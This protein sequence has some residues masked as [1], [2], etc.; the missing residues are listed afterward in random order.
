MRGEFLDLSGARLYYYAAGTRG[1]GVPVVFIHGF[2]TSG[3]LW[4]EVVPL[5]PH[6]HRLVVLD[7]LGYG[8]SDRPLNR[9][10][11]VRAHATRVIAVLDE[12]RIP[13]A[14]VVGHGI[15]GGVAQ[16]LAI[17]HPARVS[18]LCLIDSVA[19]DR[20]PT[21]EARI[22]RAS[23]AVTRYLPPELLLRVVRR[24]MQRGYA[25]HARATHSIELY[26][27]PFKEHDG[28]RALVSH[29]RAL[30]SRETIKLGRQLGKIRAPTAIVWGEHDRVMPLSVARRL[31][32]AIAGATLE[33]LPD[34]R[35]FTPEEAP[36]QIA[37]NIEALLG[38]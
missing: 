5:M 38:R 7:L 14:C 15:G 26:L 1:A 25:D 6:G 32:A 13:R 12:L 30:T 16:S 11:D 29:I 9:P 23:L 4:S 33:V 2:P 37:D 8:R 18:H 27:R 34:A 20:W 21:L 3:H 28:R 36:R 35:H 10:V 17:R 31:E 24:D 19:F 22:A